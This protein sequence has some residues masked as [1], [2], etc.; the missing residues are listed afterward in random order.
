MAT[1]DGSSFESASS[2]YGLP[3]NSNLDAL[4]A[5]KAAAAVAAAACVGTSSSVDEGGEVC[6][7][8]N[9]TKRVQVKPQSPSSTRSS[10]ASSESSSDTYNNNNNNIITS[11]M[12]SAVAI[13]PSSSTGG[14]VGIGLGLGKELPGRIKGS[15]SRTNVVTPIMVKHVAKFESVSDDE[16]KTEIG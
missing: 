9:K 3:P 16:D 2:V 11:S 4:L 7:V 13:T 6:G 5:A 14:G 1:V 12:P 15:P 8:S 10:S